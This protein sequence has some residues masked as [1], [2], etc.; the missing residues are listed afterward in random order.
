MSPGTNA[1]PPSGRRGVPVRRLPLPWRR[2]LVVG[3][4]IVAFI[5]LATAALVLVLPRFADSQ[6][7]PAPRARVAAG[8][9]HTCALKADGTVWCWG[10]NHFG[11]LG[12]GS[13]APSAVPVAVAGLGT[14]V[15]SLAGSGNHTC[16]LTAQGGVLCWGANEAG[17][18]GNGSTDNSGVPRQVTGLASGVLQVSAG[19]GHTCALVDTRAVWCWGQNGTGELG[20]G[21]TTPSPVPVPV[22]ELPGRITGVD[23]GNGFTCAAIAGTSLRCWGDNGDGQL[24]TGDGSGSLVPRPVVNLPSAAAFSVGDAH[25]C[26]VGTDGVVTCWG[27]NW[28]GQL[29]ISMTAAGSVT[30]IGVPGLPSGVTSVSAGYNRTCAVAAGSVSCWGGAMDAAAAEKAGPRAVPPLSG[31]TDVSVGAFHVCAATSQ[32]VSCWGDNSGGQLGDGTTTATD[33]PVIALVR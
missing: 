28:A 12:N 18:L 27:A 15:V 16:A 24:A 13:L 26:S 7:P 22:K 8:T 17:Q 31:V 32:A 11:Q 10:D 6:L 14:G 4:G 19:M 5:A 20:T 9:S 1:A 33:V 23:V 21:T 29:G 25:A 30:P 2:W 3:G